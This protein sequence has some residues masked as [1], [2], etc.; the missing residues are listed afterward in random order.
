MPW[1]TM[2]DPAIHIYGIRRTRRTGAERLSEKQTRRLN[3][4]LGTGNPRHEVTLAWQCYQKLR[5]IYHACPKQGRRLVAEDLA[6]FPILPNPGDR[7]ATTDLAPLENG[8]PDPLR[9]RR[10]RSLERPHRGRQQ[11][12]KTSRRIAR[13]FRNFTNCRPRCLLVADGKRSYRAAEQPPSGTKG[14]LSRG[15]IRTDDRNTSSRNPGSF[16]LAHHRTGDNTKLSRP[17]FNP[18]S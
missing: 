18:R 2:G 14:W 15:P 8:D 12:T 7:P 11:V 9:L 6:G 1:A 17:L 13:G 4:K 16:A 3:A 5:A 10:L